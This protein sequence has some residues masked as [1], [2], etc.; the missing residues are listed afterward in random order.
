MCHDGVCSLILNEPHTH[1]NIGGPLRK[2]TK[3]HPHTS[4][5]SSTL[6]HD[7]VSTKFEPLRYVGVIWFCCSC[8]PTPT[9]QVYAIK[10]ILHQQTYNEALAKIG[11]P[12][13]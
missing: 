12:L 7:W 10:H 1:Q 2:A 9:N 3:Q 13:N 11:P 6:P 4:Y 5:Q 8:S